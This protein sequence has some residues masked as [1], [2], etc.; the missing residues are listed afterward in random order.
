MY[1]LVDGTYFCQHGRTEELNERLLARN[2]PSAPLQ[3]NLSFRPALSKYSILP[4]VLPTPVSQ[5]PLKTYVKYSQDG[6]FNPGTSAPVFGYLNR[7]ED[8]SRLRN[9][10]FALQDCDQSKYIPSSR[11][12]M[13]QVGVTPQ[14]QV[15][16]QYPLLFHQEHFAPFQPDTLH[17]N[18]AVWNNH[19]KQEIFNSPCD[20][21]GCQ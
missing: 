10:H 21:Y 16:Q 12:D 15:R 17:L 7:I 20:T 18:K 11:S 5:E 2:T 19:T 3:P 1:G 4:V 8:E 14:P 6:V 9:Q 13:Y